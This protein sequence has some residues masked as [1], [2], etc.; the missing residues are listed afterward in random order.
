[1]RRTLADAQNS[2]IQFDIGIC[3][4][5]PRFIAI[6]NEAIERLI[7]EGK[8]HGTLARYRFCAI[9]GCIT[10]PPQIASIE[11]LAVCGFPSKVRSMLYEFLENGWG[12]QNSTVSVGTAGSCCGGQVAGCGVPGAIFRGRFPTFGDIIGIDKRIQLVC[13]RST[14]VGKQVL[15]LGYDQNLNWIRTIQNGTMQDGE[16]IT[17]SQSPG[18]QSANLFSSVTDLQPPDNL[19]GQWWIYELSTTTAAQRLIGQYE[20]FVT[21]PSMARYFF[22]SILQGPQSNTNSGCVQTLVDAAVKLDFTPVKNPTDYLLISSLPALGEMM[23]AI[24]KSRNEADSLRRNQIIMAGMA[25]AK[26]ILNSEL[27]HYQGSGQQIGLNIIGVNLDGCP[28]E[29]FV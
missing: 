2:N 11:A 5:D 13:D 28:V 24:V 21:R 23:S 12:I 14:D 1:M 9:D 3:G 6:L 16:V 18:T 17:L 4:T 25:V 29:N 22:P 7:I 15:C 10:L 8:W 19:D 20:Y 27:D 26:S